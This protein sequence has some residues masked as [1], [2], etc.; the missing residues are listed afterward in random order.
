[1]H[2][3]KGGGKGVRAGVLVALVVL[4]GLG[5]GHLRAAACLNAR[6]PKDKLLIQVRGFHLF[7]RLNIW[8]RC[9]DLSKLCPG[10]L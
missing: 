8:M 7:C 5:R 4:G 3:P 9:V 1:M 10:L 6:P 2:S